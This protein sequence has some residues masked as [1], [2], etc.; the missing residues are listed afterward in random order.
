MSNRSAAVINQILYAVER[1]LTRMRE[2]KHVFNS[3]Q[4]EAIYLLHQALVTELN[5]T[6]EALK[7]PEGTCDGVVRLVRPGAKGISGAVMPR[8]PREQG[9]NEVKAPDVGPVTKDLRNNLAI[10]FHTQAAERQEDVE[11]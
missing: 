1:V 4:K 8:P 9:P 3:S 2:T 6:V 11:S 10:L 5:N 7:D